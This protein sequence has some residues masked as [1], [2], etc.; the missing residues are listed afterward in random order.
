[1]KNL[2]PALG[3]VEKAILLYDFV[4]GSGEFTADEWRR[5]CQSL[6]DQHLAGVALRSIR[7]QS[8]TVPDDVRDQLQNAHFCSMER[9][10]AALKITKSALEK[11]EANGIKGVV[12][13]GP[14]I[15]RLN[16]F[17]TDR[18]Y[19]DIDFIVSP[20]DFSRA[21]ALLATLGYE[22][23]RET[24]PQRRYFTSRC[25][26]GINLRDAHGG[27]IDLHHHVSPWLWATGLTADT[28]AAHGVR[29]LI[30]GYPV[31]MAS[32]EDSLLVAALHLV[33]DHGHPGGTHRIWRDLLVIYGHCSDD[34]LV[35]AARDAKLTFWLHWVL[36]SLPPELRPVG[37]LDR[38]AA[39]ED[40]A[41]STW[42][43]RALLSKPM[44]DSPH[45][46][47]VFRLPAS[48]AFVYLLG[49]AV[50]SQQFL[51]DHF[52][53]SP[54]RYVAWWQECT[55]HLYGNAS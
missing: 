8:S 43:M 52:S 11:L 14:S 55:R 1:M 10:A 36:E 53:D 49:I 2:F 37:L 5:A 12:V 30:D 39:A 18:P 27:S 38:L 24:R 9:T 50:P 54:H 35:T 31:T 6:V 51:R 44:T 19:S 7:E 17:K 45:L 29:D 23:R 28:L 47:Q 20:D 3:R 48:S 13:K 41:H 15:A 25:R 26:E 22:E 42:R 40:D 33:S 4:P 34:I 32:P 16:R 21:T 46:S